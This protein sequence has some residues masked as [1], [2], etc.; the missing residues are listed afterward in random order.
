MNIHTNNIIRVYNNINL[1]RYENIEEKPNTE[2]FRDYDPNTVANDL[3]FESN[4]MFPYSQDIINDMMNNNIFKDKYIV[5][6]C[7]FTDSQLGLSGSFSEEINNL[8]MTNYDTFD[9]LTYEQHILNNM[10]KEINEELH[11][12]EMNENVFN[13]NIN[14]NYRQHC[15]YKEYF[16]KSGDCRITKFYYCYLCIDELFENNEIEQMNEKEIDDIYN[17]ESLYKNNI[18]HK[19]HFFIYGKRDN[20][21]NLLNNF[22]SSELFACDL[23]PIDNNLQNVFYNHANNTINHRYHKQKKHF[24]K[25]ES[26]PFIF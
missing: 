20:L 9:K 23:V 6:G 22:T 5:C 12:K 19:V 13:S 8:N 17:M 7:Y 3:F 11:L 18:S 1:E 10:I 26:E 25:I 4:S 2:V 14:I 15:I 21:L 24:S 16:K